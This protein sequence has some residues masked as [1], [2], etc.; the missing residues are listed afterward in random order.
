MASRI[1]CRTSLLRSGPAKRSLRVTVR[2]SALV[3]MAAA[4]PSRAGAVCRLFHACEGS[5]STLQAPHC[6]S[7]S[8]PMSRAMRFCRQSHSGPA[9]QL[10]VIQPDTRAASRGCVSTGVLS[11][12]DDVGLQPGP[13]VPHLLPE[14]LTSPPAVL[15]YGQHRPHCGTDDRPQHQQ[16]TFHVGSVARAALVRLGDPRTVGRRSPRTGRRTTSH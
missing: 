8:Y 7:R 14:G 15:P 5:Q 11:S 4:V 9:V 6:H 1:C 10:V 16:H 2:P 12:D 3:A 13:A